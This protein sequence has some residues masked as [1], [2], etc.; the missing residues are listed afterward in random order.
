MQQALLPQLYREQSCVHHFFIFFATPNWILRCAEPWS[1]HDEDSKSTL[2]ISGT[3]ASAIASGVRRPALYS[4][5]AREPLTYGMVVS[6][7][8]SARTPN[9]TRFW[10]FD[11]KPSRSCQPS[12]SQKTETME[13][14]LP[15]FSVRP[16]PCP[17]QL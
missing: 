16:E 6:S 9:E 2:I 7:T 12:L 5:R 10:N 3:D 8:I 17:L 13:A 4:A 14:N 1:A 15:A 11:T